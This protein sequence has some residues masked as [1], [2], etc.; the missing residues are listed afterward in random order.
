MLRLLRLMSDETYRVMGTDRGESDNEPW[1]FCAIC[2]RSVAIM[3]SPRRAVYLAN[4]MSSPPDVDQGGRYSRR[5]GEANLE[6]GVRDASIPHTPQSLL[7]HAS[8]IQSHPQYL[9]P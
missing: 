2:K 3:T 4:A 1:S 5:L 6:D 7:H 8:H 9:S